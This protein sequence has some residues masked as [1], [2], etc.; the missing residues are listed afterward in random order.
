MAACFPVELI[1]TLLLP[2]VATEFFA[3]LTSRC[4]G[5]FQNELMPFKMRNKRFQPNQEHFEVFFLK[6]VVFYNFSASS[7]LSALNVNFC[8]M[9]VQG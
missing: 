1:R 2:L 3:F 5:K 9:H 4:T 7:G 8:V 6:K